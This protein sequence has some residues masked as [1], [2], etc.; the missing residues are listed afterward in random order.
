MPR[1]SSSPNH[2]NASVAGSSSSQPPQ[3]CQGDIPPFFY[4]FPVPVDEYE[5][6]S[7]V[8][9]RRFSEPSSPGPASP[10]EDLTRKDDLFVYPPLGPE[11]GRDV[12]IDGSVTIVRGEVP[13]DWLF[14][15]LR[16]LRAERRKLV[17]EVNTLQSEVK[18]AAYT[19]KVLQV[20][21]K[22]EQEA[23]DDMIKVLRQTIDPSRVKEAMEIVTED[24][25]GSSDDES[26]GS[27]DADDDNASSGS[28]DSSPGP[29]PKGHQHN[30]ILGKRPRE[31][32]DSDN[33]LEDELEVERSLDISQDDIP[34]P[35]K[36]QRLEGSPISASVSASTSTSSTSNSDL[37]SDDAASSMPFSEME[38]RSDDSDTSDD[39]YTSSEGP[40]HN[41]SGS[42]LSVASDFVPTV[43]DNGELGIVFATFPNGE[44]R[45]WGR[46]LA[47][48][49]SEGED[50]P[51]TP[52]LT[53]D[54]LFA[55]LDATSDDGD[56]A[57]EADTSFYDDTPTGYRP[58][59]PEF[60][61]EF[62]R[63]AMPVRFRPGFAAPTR[64]QG[65]G[66]TIYTVEFSDP[67]FHQH[68]SQPGPIRVGPSELTLQF[69]P[70]RNSGTFSDAVASSSRRSPG[71][72]QSSET[73]MVLRRRTAPL[74]R[75][76]SHV[77]QDRHGNVWEEDE[78]PED[79]DPEQERGGRGGRR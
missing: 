31:E 61:G 9:P 72:G 32:Q 59:S 66:G 7:P 64:V 45:R 11:V 57:P 58:D 46:V 37:Y 49:P 29:S 24:L 39:R 17:K 51:P 42:E 15:M 73:R 18:A 69:P 10:S 38:F 5:D 76:F 55:L 62:R 25:D 3:S 1:S 8:S 14:Q 74:K 36:R 44:T 20:H 43:E 70:R 21:L 79:Y 56:E 35:R 28:S 68:N 71:T 54:E 33:E 34:S 19:H 53:E 52:A 48:Q 65:P 22:A 47:I 30:S 63:P 67:A 40:V 77:Y 26:D 78:T 60:D 41:S 4:K 2:D 12:A 6:G 27:G 23:T 75:H 50:E 13:G 16:D